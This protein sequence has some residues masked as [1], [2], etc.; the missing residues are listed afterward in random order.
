LDSEEEEEETL[1]HLNNV[2]GYGEMVDVVLSTTSSPVSV[3]S[4]HRAR[5]LVHDLEIGSELL[6]ED[7]D[8]VDN[9]T[10]DGMDTEDEGSEPEVFED[11]PD[12]EAEMERSQQ[13]QS[14]SG[15]YVYLLQRAMD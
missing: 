15:E 13:G 1:E 6:Q 7:D 12:Y 8:Y 9:D 5:S 4:E 3:A 10:N 14:S 11:I 2:Q